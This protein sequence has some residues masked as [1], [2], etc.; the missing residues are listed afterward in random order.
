MS[1]RNALLNALRGRSVSATCDILRAAP[2][3]SVGSDIPAVVVVLASL[4]E[5]AQQRRTDGMIRAVC[6]KCVEI[7]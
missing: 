5:K 6:D 3:T 2:V 1:L 7:S 4:M